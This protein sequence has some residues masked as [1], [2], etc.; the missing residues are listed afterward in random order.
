MSKNS[1]MLASR[2]ILSFVILFFIV[3]NAF[4][5]GNEKLIQDGNEAYEKEQYVEA[6]SKSGKYINRRDYLDMYMDDSADIAEEF[7]TWGV[8]KD[9]SHVEGLREELLDLRRPGDD[10]FVFFK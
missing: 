1:K 10:Q 5:Q 9:L 7:L 8:G 3:G 4:G 6:I 2:H